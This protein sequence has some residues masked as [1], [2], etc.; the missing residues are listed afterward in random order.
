MPLC[1]VVKLSKLQALP[2]GPD[3]DNHRPPVQSFD[4]IKPAPGPPGLVTADDGL[5]PCV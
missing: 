5:L 2:L 4:K 1:P 3:F